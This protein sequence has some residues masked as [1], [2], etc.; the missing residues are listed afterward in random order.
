MTDT[1]QPSATPAGASADYQ[2]TIRVKASP[3]ELFDALT[4]VSALVAWW[5]PATG[6]GDADGESA[7]TVQHQSWTASRC[8]LAAGITTSRAC[9]IT[10]KSAAAALSEAPQIKP[11]APCREPRDYRMTRKGSNPQVPSYL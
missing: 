8:A 2:K 10:S 3:G 1:E 9:V 5:V 6:S 7:T 4:S 11:G